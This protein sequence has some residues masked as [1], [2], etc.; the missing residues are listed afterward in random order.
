MCSTMGCKC[1]QPVI[2]VSFDGTGYGDDGAVW[3][4]E[5]LIANYQN[6]SESI[7]SGLCTPPG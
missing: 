1:D 4:G 2:G 5:F 7:P 3:G 6:L